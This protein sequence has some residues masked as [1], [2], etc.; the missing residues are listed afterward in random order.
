[1]GEAKVCSRCG[2]DFP[3]TS[4]YFHRQ[5]DGKNG[6][7]ADCKKCVKKSS[8]EYYE[9]NKESITKYNREYDRVNQKKTTERQKTYHI[10]HNEHRIDY[11]KIYREK[12]RKLL[13]ENKRKSYRANHEAMLAMSKRYK[14][15]HR[16][17][18][19]ERDKIW[20]LAN[21]P[22]INI[23]HQRRR[24]RERQ[25]LSTLTFVQWESIKQHFDNKCCYC[26]EEK[27]LTIEHFIPV[28]KSGEL[29]I[30]N[31]LP[32]CASCNCSKGAKLL[33][34]W[35]PRQPFYSKEREQKILKYL[36]YKNKIQQFS[37]SF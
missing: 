23:A 32:S 34:E 16:V 13:A 6:L 33:N 30:N 28:S 15:S 26:G 12:N 22:K 27:K 2:E 19:R 37:L 21:R 29:S 31:V 7:R 17:E 10:L 5:K 36:N 11:G 14:D 20:S 35:Y 9:L 25:L 1:M 18:I 3:P 24:A 8:H 4:E